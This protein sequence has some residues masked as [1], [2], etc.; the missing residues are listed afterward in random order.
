MNN[1]GANG[2]RYLVGDYHQLARGV[3]QC[4]PHLG[5]ESYP[6]AIC[7]ALSESRPGA[8]PVAVADTASGEVVALA[9]APRVFEVADIATV[10]EVMRVWDPSPALARELAARE[11]FRR[12]PQL[13]GA[14]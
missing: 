13:G 6:D 5:T 11:A 14:G 4:L 10:E 1:N 7:M 9:I 8:R 2:M 12:G 3:A